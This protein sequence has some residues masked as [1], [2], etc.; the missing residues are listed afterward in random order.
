MITVVVGW[1]AKTQLTDTDFISSAL[2]ATYYDVHNKV[3]L[4]ETMDACFSDDG[5]IK[6]LGFSFSGGS[7]E[8]N[9]AGLPLVW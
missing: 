2:E 3:C 4:L 1:G 5:F 7:A 6:A 9:C 8:D